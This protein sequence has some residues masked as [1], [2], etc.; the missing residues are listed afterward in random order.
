MT[1]EFW[2]FPALEFPAAGRKI[3]FW[4]RFKEPVRAG[5]DGGSRQ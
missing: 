2:N 4:K 3:P 5:R 1:L